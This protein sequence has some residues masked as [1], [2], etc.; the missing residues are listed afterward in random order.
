MEKY[1]YSFFEPAYAPVQIPGRGVGF[2]ATP[3]AA[4]ILVPVAV[5]P[6]PILPA[7]PNL[8]FLPSL[9]SLASLTTLPS[10]PTTPTSSRPDSDLDMIATSTT[11]TRLI[12]SCCWEEDQQV[13]FTAGRQLQ[14]QQWTDS[15][16]VLEEERGRVETRMKERVYE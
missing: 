3:P 9:A 1:G 12:R 7:L 16:K 11:A 8:S 13:L 5:A 15:T 6:P 14:R 2:V 4:P 10:F